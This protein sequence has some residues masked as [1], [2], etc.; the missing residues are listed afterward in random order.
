LVLVL[1]RGR[2]ILEDHIIFSFQCRGAF[3][4]TVEYYY[5]IA[6]L[7][8]FFPTARSDQPWM[9]F[10]VS[11]FPYHFSVIVVETTISTNFLTF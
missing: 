3:K 7:G 1:G 4:Y 10:A 2:E 6:Q 8:G 5:L 9:Y 11:I